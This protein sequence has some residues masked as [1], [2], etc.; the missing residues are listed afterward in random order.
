MNLLFCKIWEIFEQ[1]DFLNKRTGTNQ[2]FLL[3]HKSGLSRS[4][5]CRRCQRSRNSRPP[6]SASHCAM[7]TCAIFVDPFCV[8]TSKTVSEKE[9]QNIQN[10]FGAFHILL[11][12]NCFV[13]IFLVCQKLRPCPSP[14]KKTPSR[15]PVGSTRTSTARSRRPRRP[16]R[17]PDGSGLVGKGTLFWYKKGRNLGKI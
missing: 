15:S 10:H 16:R 3:S 1:S 6:I 13:P 8:G 11:T 17:T 5:A 12:K 2:L 14:W 9:S 4:F 7:S